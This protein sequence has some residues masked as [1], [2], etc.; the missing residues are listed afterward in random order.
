LPVLALLAAA[1]PIAIAAAPAAAQSLRPTPA[2]LDRQNR[3][4]RLH[5]YTYLVT[6]AQ[7]RKFVELGYLVPIPG[8]RDYEV[9][10]GTSFPVARPAVK[11]FLEHLSARFHAECGERLTVTSLTRP[12]TR[13]PWNASSRSVHPTGMAVDLRVPATYRCRRWLA[14]TLVSLEGAGVLEANRE[15]HPPHYH[16]AVFPEPYRAYLAS[17]AVGGDDQVADAA[18]DSPDPA[19]A[20]RYQVRRGDTLWRIA[21]SHG[22]SV[23]EIKAANEIRTN[24]IE[25][26][27]VLEIPSH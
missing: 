27:Q 3:E 25:P 23:A 20:V 26:G 19:V 13:Q 8:D 6:P 16:V 14:T 5:G 11:L 7:V 21:H 17:L 22:T 18:A 10:P 9:K 15:H 1:L 12:K 2:S 4:A 24:R